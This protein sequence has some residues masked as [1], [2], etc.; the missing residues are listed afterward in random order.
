MKDMMEHEGYYGSVHYDD[1]DRVF[2]GKLEFIPGLISYEGQDVGSLRTAF[3]EAVE[4]YFELC[5]AQ[6]RE[7]ERPFKGTFSVR[8]G[9]ELHRAVALTAKQKGM[10]LNRF[11]VQ[12]LKKASQEAQ[13]ER[14][15]DK[16]RGLNPT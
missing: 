14:R 4:E 5:R 11:V 6:G 3:E 16:A 1:E 7:P 8:V 9:Q 2:Y 10:S 13:S 15:R 12:A